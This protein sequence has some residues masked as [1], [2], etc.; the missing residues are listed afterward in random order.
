MWNPGTWLKSCLSWSG[1]LMPSGRALAPSSR[2][3][4]ACLGWDTLFEHFCTDSMLI[5]HLTKK[6]ENIPSWAQS[7]IVDNV[8]SRTGEQAVQS[9]PLP[10]SCYH[11][12]LY[13][14]FCREWNPLF[15][16]IFARESLG[17]TC[18]RSH[19]RACNEIWG[20]TP[21]SYKIHDPKLK[22]WIPMYICILFRAT[23]KVPSN[24]LCRQLLSTPKVSNL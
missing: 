3:F 6:K 20:S 16:I 2:L 22:Y 18:S 23:L 4:F 21:F 15:W 7:W 11:S 12:I 19:Y 17:Y 24:L 1:P 14:K 8:P 5:S 10:E 13:P 9:R